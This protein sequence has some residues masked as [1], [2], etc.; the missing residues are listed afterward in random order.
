MHR[1]FQLREDQFFLVL[2]VLIGVLGGL[3]VVCFRI[4][5]EWVQFTLLGSSLAPTFPRVVLAPTLA[6]FAVALLAIYVFPHVARQRRE[7][8]ESGG[9]H[10]EWL[11]AVHHSDRKICDV[12]DCDWQ[13]AVAGAGRPVAAD[14]RGH[15]VA[16]WTKAAAF[17]G[18]S[19]ADRASWRGGGIAAAFNAPISAV[20]F[21]IEEVIGQWSAGV[22]AAIVLS[23]VAS[24]ATMRA[25][26]G[27]ASLFRV[28][29]F[30]VT[31]PRDL[32]AYAALGIA[33]GFASLI[34]LKWIVWARPRMKALP[35]W[36]LYFQ[37]A[38]AGLLIGLIGIKVPQVMGAGIPIVDPG[39]AR[40][41]PVEYFADPDGAENYRDGSFVFERIAG[42]NI[43]ADAIYRGDAGRGG[44]IDR[45][46]FFSQLERDGGN[47]CAGGN[48]DAVCG[49]FAHAELRRC[50]W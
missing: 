15:C 14:G 9:V 16:D 43:C 42:R 46:A 32:I 27:P 34:L 50:S 48:W 18:E 49:I 5:I 39:D 23:A 29:P 25:F 10:F 35:K 11:R 41:V 7:S 8:D 20:L 33:G 36:T 30:R 24:V 17:D 45:A 12:R 3:S 47:V 22:L 6:G 21:V 4:F 28:P 19:A 26:L 37:P 38:A 1:V 31:G 40:A 2:A 13:R 44:G